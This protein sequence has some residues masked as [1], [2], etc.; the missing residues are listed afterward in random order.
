VF[1]RGKKNIQVLEKKIPLCILRNNFLRIETQQFRYEHNIAFI[2][3]LI[4][5][6]LPRQIAFFFRKLTQKIDQVPTAAKIQAISRTGK[7]SYTR[8]PP[9]IFCAGKTSGVASGVVFMSSHIT[10]AT[11]KYEPAALSFKNL[12]FSQGCAH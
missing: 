2:F 5:D 4:I 8:I 6:R 1:A 10:P 3:F 11:H 7:Y 9:L 12:L